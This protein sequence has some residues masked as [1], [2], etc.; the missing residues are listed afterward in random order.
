MII[1]L[2]VLLLF[3]LLG[4]IITAFFNLPIPGPV[5]GMVLLFF[6]LTVRGSVP[7]NLEHTSQGLLRHL[8]LLFVPA[9]S[10]IVTYFALLAEEWIPL[11]VALVASTVI[12]IAS[13]A[14]TMKGL[15][16]AASTTRPKD[17]GPLDA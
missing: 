17:T 15:A 7:Q 5:V 11:A 12:T 9:G 2:A 6:A 10:G 16:R 8:S 14:L 1:G 3:Q 4:E 13:T